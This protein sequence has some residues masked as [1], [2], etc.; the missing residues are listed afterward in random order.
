MEIYMEIRESFFF[1]DLPFRIFLFMILLKYPVIGVG[2]KNQSVYNIR[3]KMVFGGGKSLIS[4]LVRQWAR[5]PD[6]LFSD[7]LRRT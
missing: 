7:M 2:D 6:T 4:V 1:S 5:D 3:I